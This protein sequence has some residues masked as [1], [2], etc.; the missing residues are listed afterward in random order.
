MRKFAVGL[1]LASAALVNA[2][3]ATV[4]AFSDNFEGTLAAWTDRNPSSPDAAIVDDPLRQGNH[5][6]GFNRTQSGGS[7]FTTDFVT[8]SGQ[9]TVSFE[10][11]GLAK[12]GSVAGDLGGFFGISQN[13]PGNHQWI[14]GTQDGFGQ[15]INLID[16]N[17]WHTYTLTFNSTVGQTVHLMFEDFSGS[18]GVAGD[19]FFDN[20]S[21]NDSSVAPAPFSNVPEPGTI[22]LLG[23]G[24]LAATTARRR[25]G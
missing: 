18:S 21:F 11:L 15:P 25:R 2:N 3:A 13:F 6:L 4:T 24:L 5:V 19:A 8:S 10:Y 22:A 12:Q 17:T 14:A 7:I 20:I 1:A 23:L 9:F 16:D